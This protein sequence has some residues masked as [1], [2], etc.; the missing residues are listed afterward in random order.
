M[1]QYEILVSEIMYEAL[2]TNLHAFLTNLGRY[3]SMHDERAYI[4]RV[5]LFLSRV[6]QL[7]SVATLQS[8]Y[9]Q[10]TISIT[11]IYLISA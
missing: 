3:R 2:R 4:I 8:T 5:K 11:S 7:R 1:Q 10:T 9:K 6:G